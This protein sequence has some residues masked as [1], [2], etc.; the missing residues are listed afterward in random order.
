MN[1]EIIGRPCCVGNKDY[2]FFLYFQIFIFFE[3]K[4]VQGECIITTREHC[5]LR[6]GYFHDNAHLCSQV[7]KKKNFLKKNFKIFLK[8]G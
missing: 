6:K 7:K 4:G 3:F 2:Y 8:K 1:C 5:D